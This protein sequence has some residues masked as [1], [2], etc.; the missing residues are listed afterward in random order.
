[1]KNFTFATIAASALAALT[2]GLAAPAIAAPE[3]P[4]GTQDTVTHVQ[5]KK[6]SQGDQ[7][8]YGDKTPYGGYQNNHKRQ[9]DKNR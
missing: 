4:A 8:G 5:G 2:I 9:S 3:G 6:P 1:M 7:G